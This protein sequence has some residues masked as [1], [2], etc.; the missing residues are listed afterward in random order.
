MASRFEIER[1][2]VRRAENARDLLGAAAHAAAAARATTRHPLKLVALAELNR[3]ADQALS[4]GI[5]DAHAAGYSWREIG[6]LTGL[7]WQSLHRI[8]RA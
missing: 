7:P 1:A 4:Q 2:Y 6:D 8:Y 5:I 3:L